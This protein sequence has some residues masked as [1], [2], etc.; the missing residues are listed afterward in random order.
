VLEN[1]L[2]SQ[3]LAAAI[4]GV[5]ISIVSSP[6]DNIKTKLMTSPKGTY[7]GIGHCAGKMMKH[8]GIRSFYRGFM[9]QC[10][11]MSPFVMIQ[12]I[13]FETLRRLSGLSG[14]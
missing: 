2:E 12:L 7:T 3:V 8:G 6:I 14:M 4:T 13:T 11:S 1:G 9:P 10:L 5:I